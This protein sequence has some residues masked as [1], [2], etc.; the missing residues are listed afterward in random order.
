MKKFVK[1]GQNFGVVPI[2]YDHYGPRVVDPLKR[3]VSQ[4]IEINEDGIKLRNAWK[5]K[6]EGLSDVE[7][8][9]RLDGV[10]VKITK[11]NISAM[12]R[13]PFYIGVQT[14]AFLDGKPIKGN[15]EPL[16]SEEVFWRVQNIL[17]GNNQGYTIEKN[18]DSRPLI[19]TLLLPCLR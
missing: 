11:Q 18:N 19:G 13:R 9:R 5:W 15:W 16:I 3:D 12:W 8:I 14:N 17:E 1:S 7:I 4:R 10:G 2:G 6:L